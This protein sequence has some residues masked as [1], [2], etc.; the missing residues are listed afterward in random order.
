MLNAVLLPFGRGIG[1]PAHALLAIIIATFVR[2]LGWIA[3]E[4]AMKAV[5]PLHIAGIA[6]ALVLIIAKMRPLN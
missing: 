4:K 3:A 6:L 1:S 2:P 5:K